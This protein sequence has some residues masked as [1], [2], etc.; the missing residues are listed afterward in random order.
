MKSNSTMYFR[1]KKISI[2]KFQLL[3]AITIIGLLT[4]P[5]NVFTWGGN[6][7]ITI[8]QDAYLT[9]KSGGFPQ[10]EIFPDYL[11]NIL[12]AYTK[13]PDL[14]NKTVNHLSASV[15]TW[16]LTG[17]ANDCIKGI[18]NNE[19][20]KTIIKDL[21]RATHYIQDMNCPHHS[22]EKYEIGHETFEKRATFGF[23]SDEKFDGFQ[24]IANFDNFVYNSAR[25]SKRYIKFDTGEFY[26]NPY[27]YEKV[28]EQ[29]WSH[30]VND[31]LDLW[32][33]VFYLGLGED[34]YNEVGFP[35]RE[36][37]RDEKKIDY[38]PVTLASLGLNDLNSGNV[39][40]HGHSALGGGCFITSAYY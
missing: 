3:K 7:H 36:G 6:T 24:I 34:K 40:P 38:P 14:Y 18:K 31:V 10:K 1:A 4:V 13:E 37:N 11:W 15:C 9:L 30:T 20:W 8:A 22:I 27:F 2:A 5:T 26:S 17:H 19:D 21:G 12:I 28:M 39:A 33:T 29:L 25:F 32:L 16:K 23:W 35:K